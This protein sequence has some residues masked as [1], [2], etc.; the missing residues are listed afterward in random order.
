MSPVREHYNP[1]IIS[2]L[3]EHDRLPHDKVDERK[4]FQRQILFL[5]NAIKAEE[6]E[7]SFS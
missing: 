1:A 6:F 4:S 7:T 2:L 5:M 3:R